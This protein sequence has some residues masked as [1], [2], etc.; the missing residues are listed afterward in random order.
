MQE[1]S[2]RT[3][4]LAIAAGLA[5]VLLVGGGGFL[6]GRMTA[7]APPAPLPPV[8][9]PGPAPSL[10]P[11][12][13]RD[14]ER[15]DLIALGQRAADSFASGETLPKKIRDAAGR[16]FSLWLPFGCAGPTDA[17]SG[18]SMRW[19]YDES[20]E[21]LR[22]TADPVRWTAA[23]WGLDGAR[24][25]ASAEGF[26]IGR[27]WLSSGACPA[28]TEQAVPRGTEAITLPGQSLAIAQFTFNE[29]D[30]G[31]RDGVRPF[32][33]VQR[34]AKGRFDGSAGFRLRVNGRIEPVS[35][36][37]PVRCVQP[38]GNEQRPICVIGALIDSV[39]LENPAS[40][41]TLATWSMRRAGQ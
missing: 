19:R 29:G 11:E 14:L 40:G 33:T 25:P 20:S 16:R 31:T 36:G 30:R 38:A 21:V 4:R 12:A 23:D 26:W 6:I 32:E 7:S 24:A 18:L 41:E 28:R 34:I 10:A 37:E 27:P 1:P 13:A 15:A 9:A 35:G 3:S 17:D 5:A 39:E 8:V 2:A 22:V